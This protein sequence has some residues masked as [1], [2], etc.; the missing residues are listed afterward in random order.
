L[1]L[2]SQSPLARFFAGDELRKDG[3]A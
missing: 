3:D 2:D 1:F